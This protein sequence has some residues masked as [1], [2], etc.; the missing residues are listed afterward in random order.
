MI[1]PQ[2]KCNAGLLLPTQIKQ[3]HSLHFLGRPNTRVLLLWLHF[4]AGNFAAQPGILLMP[5]ALRT[6]LSL[7]REKGL[8][9]ERERNIDLAYAPSFGQRM[10][11][12][13]I[14]PKGRFPWAC[15]CWL[16][17]GRRNYWKDTGE[18]QSSMITEMCS[19]PWMSQGFQV[20]FNINPWVL[21]RQFMCWINIT[22]HRKTNHGWSF[23]FFLM[24]E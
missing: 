12:L 5:D 17:R 13:Q 7:C 16:S 23:H 4:V 2:Q 9:K 1:R 24:K 18:E 22:I 3:L 20:Q 19:P 11:W 14:M 15:V 10:Q 6:G 21:M 8:W